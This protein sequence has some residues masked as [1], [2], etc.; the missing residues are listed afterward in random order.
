MLIFNQFVGLFLQIIVAKVLWK[1][2]RVDA[3]FEEDIV[4]SSNLTNE[5]TII[6]K[7]HFDPKQM[8]FN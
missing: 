1:G 6:L 7:T 2:G 8:K 5:K 3:A 4:A